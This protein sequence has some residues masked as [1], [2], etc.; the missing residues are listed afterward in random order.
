MTKIMVKNFL[1]VIFLTVF[2][3]QGAAVAYAVTGPLPSP[4]EQEI[5]KLYIGEN[6]V[7][8]VRNP[9][10]VAIGNPDVADVG[11]VS[12]QE[13]TLVPKSPGSTTLVFWDNYGEQA[14]QIRVFNENMDVIK[15]RVDSLLATLNVPKVYTQA[16]EDE[17]RVLVL[18]T[19][20]T[21]QIKERISTALETLKKKIVD[22]IVVK[23][24][25]ATVEIDVQILELN[26]DATDTL[27]FTWPGSTGYFNITDSSIGTTSAGNFAKLFNVD[28]FTRSSFSFSWKLDLLVQEGKARILSQ[29]RLACQSGKEAQ[30]HVGGEKPI[31]T[32]SVGDGGG[33]GTEVEYKEYG[34]K[35]KVKPVVSED[36][37]IRLALEVEVSDVG[38]AEYIGASTV[39]SAQAY[40]LSKRSAS[41]ELFMRDGD[42]MSIGGLI[43]QKSEEDL[44]KFPWLADVP[45]LGMFFRQRVSRE[46][47]G[48]GERGN[49]ELFIALTPKIISM[50]VEKNATEQAVA[51]VAAPARVEV[52]PRVRAKMQYIEEKP[53][54]P[55]ATVSA[56]DYAQLIQQQIERK[57][58][59]P[60][61]AKKTGFHGTVKLWMH[62]SYRG[63]LLEIGIKRSSGFQVLDFHAVAIARSIS[64]YPP[65]P[66]S[67]SQED[68]WVDIPVTYS[69]N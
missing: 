50:D 19:V 52:L 42:T 55:E 17:E 66:P 53:S 62:I 39:R 57:L 33:E 23:E 45:V 56:G 11:A 29:P 2:L 27:G 69:L 31:F 43:K 46:G 18:G 22:L 61:E 37:R 14:Y 15:G 6:K 9:T 3:F 8:P 34:I 7:L 64:P 41:T 24:S 59:Y 28:K 5:L 35:L 54:F 26:R 65:F 63:E 48:S 60:P 44:R 51:Q 4:S 32:T 1:R 13:L 36:R 38:T 49:T 16:M 21:P 40:P 25:E 20:S 58:S 30:L 12:N 67:L 47:G 10:R 68:I